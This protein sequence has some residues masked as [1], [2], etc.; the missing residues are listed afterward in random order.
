SV[1]FRGQRPSKVKLLGGEAGDPQLLAIISSALPIPVEVGR[2]LYSVDTS[3]L[4]QADQRG[5]LNE[6][7]VAFGLGLKK[8]NH[9]FGAKD[10]KHR[11]ALFQPSSAA[12]GHV[13][14]VD[15]SQA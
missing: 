9:Y 6:W 11:E 7:A 2:P 3:R 4:R 15:L 10:G 12:V 14:V 13:E 8:T 5:Y 1:T